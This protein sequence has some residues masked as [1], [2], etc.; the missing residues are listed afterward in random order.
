MAGRD[1]M[2]QALPGA[3]QRNGGRDRKH[4]DTERERER[5]EFMPLEVPEGS[6]IVCEWMQQA[7]LRRGGSGQQNYKSGAALGESPVPR[8]R[9]AAPFPDRV[10]HSRALA[11]R[12][13]SGTRPGKQ[14]NRDDIRHVA[15]ESNDFTPKVTRAVRVQTV[16][17]ESG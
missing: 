2:R 17:G 13:P 6:E 12:S 1:L 16:N 15:C 14:T 8:L 3:Q 9:C 11:E 4:D 7:A 10:R 5:G